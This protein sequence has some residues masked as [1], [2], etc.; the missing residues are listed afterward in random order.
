MIESLESS[1]KNKQLK[2]S[3]NPENEFSNFL[4]QSEKELERELN[5]FPLAVKIGRTA[6]TK[7]EI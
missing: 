3:N 1:A 4:P 7:I 6:H 2:E 5:T